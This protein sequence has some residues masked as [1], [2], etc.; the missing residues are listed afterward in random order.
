M[1][2]IQFKLT[3]KATFATF[4]IDLSLE[5]KL[6]DDELMRKSAKIDLSRAMLQAIY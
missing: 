4:N 5:L 6:G 2:S 1:Q 3:N